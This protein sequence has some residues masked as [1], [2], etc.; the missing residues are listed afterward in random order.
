VEEMGPGGLTGPLDESLELRPQFHG[1][2]T[3]S[4][5]DGL[6]PGAD[7]GKEL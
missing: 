7:L 1:A 4:A 3:V 6:G 5:D 2:V